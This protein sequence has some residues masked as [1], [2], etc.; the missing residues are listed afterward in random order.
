[1][2]DV[3]YGKW[4]FSYSLRNIILIYLI[5]YGLSLRRCLKLRRCLT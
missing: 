3:E 4:N 2:S 5:H 1:M